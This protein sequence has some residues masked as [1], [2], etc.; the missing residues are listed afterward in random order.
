MTRCAVC[1]QVRFPYAKQCVELF[2]KI[3]EK[4]FSIIFAISQP[5]SKKS[6]T[7]VSG[8]LG[9]LFDE[10]K[11][12]VSCQGPFQ[13]PFWTALKSSQRHKNPYNFRGDGGVAQCGIGSVGS[14][15]DPEN[16]R[17]RFCK[18]ALTDSVYH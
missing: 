14:G 10:I 8:T 5:N 12:G 16:R 4:S 15:P 6:L 11:T 17:K 7:C 9:R 3:F 18:I 1:S 13:C 2:A